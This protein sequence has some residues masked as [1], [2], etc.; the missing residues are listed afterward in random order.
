M[1]ATYLSDERIFLCGGI[2]AD[3][4][5]VSDEA[6]V[7]EVRGGEKIAINRPTSFVNNNN[8]LGLKFEKL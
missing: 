6:F 3:F 7:Y 4:E 8:L 2:N 5:Y 1:F